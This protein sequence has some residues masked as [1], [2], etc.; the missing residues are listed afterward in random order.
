[1]NRVCFIEEEEL[2]KIEN[3]LDDINIKSVL[4]D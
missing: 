4:E 2:P 1:M 3:T